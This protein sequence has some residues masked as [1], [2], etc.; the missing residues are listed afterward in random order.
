[1]S[2]KYLE[3]IAKMLKPPETPR[4]ERA[5]HRPRKIKKPKLRRFQHYT[6]HG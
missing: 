5:I 1:M 3:K 2:N 4:S 6:G